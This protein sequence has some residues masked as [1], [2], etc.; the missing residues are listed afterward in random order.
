MEET[1]APDRDESSV[2]QHGGCGTHREAPSTSTSTAPCSGT[3]VRLTVRS[4]SS[5]IVHASTLF[6]DGQRSSRVGVRRGVFGGT[7]GGRSRPRAYES[8]ESPGANPGLVHLMRSCWV[9]LRSKPMF[10]VIVLRSGGALHFHHASRKLTLEP[11][12]L[13]HPVRVR[14]VVHSVVERGHLPQPALVGRPTRNSS[15]Q[16]GGNIRRL[17]A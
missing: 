15:R 17:A 4:K 7:W 10:R 13:D 14:I 5:S 16:V 1:F 9:E 12:I 8:D 3:L 6:L 2:H 11:K